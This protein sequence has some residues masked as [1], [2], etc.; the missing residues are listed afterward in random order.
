MLGLLKG[1]TQK[2]RPV[3][4][5]ALIAEARYVVVDTELTGLDEKKDSIVSLGAVR[6]TGGRIDVGA[7]FYRL[8]SPESELSAKSVVIH[9][10]TPSEVMEKPAIDA[11]LRE[12]TEFCGDDLVVGH[13][14]SIDLEFINREMLRTQGSAL[15][16]PAVD[17]FSV[18]EWL[19]KRSK[20][21]T[22][23]SRQA[24]F[25]LY[26]IVRE[27]GIPVNGAH[28]ALMDAFITAQLFQ[29]LIP[30]LARTGVYEIEELL[31]I[32]SPF[33]GGDRFRL[34]GEFGNF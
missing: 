34:T 18:H 14:V 12:F 22:G 25:R 29:R 3:D 30:L 21:Q 10:I 26:D 28:N 9:E 1:I 20:A 6:M 2:R 4:E 31:R 27:F 11:V 24:G 19:R 7:T 5:H 15:A 13:F 17:T 16:N 32:G 23:D 8:A 33:K